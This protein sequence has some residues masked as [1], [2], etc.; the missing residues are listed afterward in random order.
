[1]DFPDIIN[2]DKHLNYMNDTENVLKTTLT[3]TNHNI[4]LC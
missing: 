4:P 2:A 1:M 3:I